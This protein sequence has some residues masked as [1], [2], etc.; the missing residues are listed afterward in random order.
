VSSTQIKTTVPG[1]ASTGPLTVNGVSAGSPTFTVKLGA[2]VS[3]AVARPAAPLT[4]SAAG[5]DPDVGIDVYFDTS[6]EALV[7]SDDN[8]TLSEADLFPVPA[9]ATPG[10]HWV[11]LVE[12]GSSG[13]STRASVR[14]GTSWA[15]EG[16]N[17]AHTS[18]NPAEN[19]LNASNVSG[20][21]QAW[22]THVTSG[23]LDTATPIV[24]AGTGADGTLY[25]TSGG[26]SSS[27]YALD[28]L[29]G[30]LLWTGIP[31]TSSAQLVT[32]A[33]SA[34]KVFVVDQA[35][36]QLDVFSASCAHSTCA[37]TGWSLAGSASPD[38]PPVVSGS[39]VLVGDDVNGIVAFSTSCAA[40]CTPLWKGDGSITRVTTAPALTT[41][42]TAI[43]SQADRGSSAF[44]VLLAAYSVAGCGSA[45]CAP[46]DRSDPVFDDAG[47]PIVGGG[48][49]FVSD[50]STGATLAYSATCLA[51][52]DW[53]TATGLSYPGGAAA[54]DHGVRYGTG[55]DSSG[56]LALIGQR[57]RDGS[58]VWQTPISTADWE[59]SPAIAN[60]VIYIDVVDPSGNHELDAYDE[61]CS[62]DCPPLWSGSVAGRFA[63]PPTVVNGM[64]YATSTN[65]NVYAFS[66]AAPPPPTS[67]PPA[68]SLQAD[69]S[70]AMT[71]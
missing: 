45:T 14:V 51:C 9:G 64:V 58:V 7:S 56:D 63:S 43:V 44:D 38:S 71:H 49:A 32:V 42:G 68:G 13:K 69:R 15:E 20:L 3:P 57:A 36:R 37:P 23:Y 8:G 39:R 4:V 54:F 27:L 53:S 18:V 66:L 1:L 55:T 17:G 31:H 40:N 5:L 47:P 2:L 24:S 10:K 28:P 22:V 33:V 25:V 21:D 70:L 50:E 52:G 12:R 16:F 6:D 65:G 34:G 29:T 11:T 48:R 62:F 26:P 61:N 67:P 60:G 46:I 41:A 59:S 30:K 19:V 35:N